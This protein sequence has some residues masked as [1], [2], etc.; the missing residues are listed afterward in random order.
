MKLVFLTAPKDFHA[1]F[2]VQ[3]FIGAIKDVEIQLAI[4]LVSS[5]QDQRCCY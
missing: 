1:H 3:Q 2:M 5:H 4:R